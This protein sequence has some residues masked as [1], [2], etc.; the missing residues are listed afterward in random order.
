MSWMQMI[1]MAD[2]RAGN[3]LNV[4]DQ[5][6][7]RV[8]AVRQ[9]N[10]D[11]AEAITLKG[12][13]LQEQQRINNFKMNMQL[14]DH[15]LRSQQMALQERLMPLK[16]QT[17]Q[18]RL[19][20]QQRQL[21]LTERSSQAAMFNAMYGGYDNILAGDLID[22]NNAALADEAIK[23]K[24]EYMERLLRGEQF[25]G[26][27]Y[28]Q[29]W[30]GRSERIKGEAFTPGDGYDASIHQRL[31]VF[32]EAPATAYGIKYNPEVKNN[33][34]GLAMNAIMGGGARSI[35][36]LST[37]AEYAP[38]EMQ[39]ITEMMNIYSTNENII[40]SQMKDALDL[41][42]QIKVVEDEDTKRTLI[43]YHKDVI[44][45]INSARKQNRMIID[46]AA[47]E[48]FTLP[49][50]RDTPVEEEIERLRLPEE[51]PTRDAPKTGVATKFPEAFNQPMATKINTKAADVERTLGLYTDNQIDMNKFEASPLG[52]I[53]FENL[54]TNAR[55]ITEDLEL[56]VVKQV[57]NKSAGLKLED[58][59]INELIR[60]AGNDIDLKASKLISDAAW[61]VSP[62]K[63]NLRV[64]KNAFNFSG[65][66]QDEARKITISPLGDD[67]STSKLQSGFVIRNADDLFNILA[68]VPASKRQAA[69]QE[70]Y[71]LLIA[72]PII[73]S[74]R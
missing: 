21:E 22:N 18:L 8:L 17:E 55:A 44:N 63:S 52:G 15:G 28:L 33:R 41:E 46:S 30:R 58:F 53:D 62:M 10:A 67:D 60:L 37:G 4:M 64:A 65:N 69:Q 24:S 42:K 48:R 26:D 11:K 47:N 43:E 7:S 68:K 36:E 3:S 19:Q 74:A 38:E 13:E 9:N 71:S 12:I 70:L 34:R 2:R 14:A 73:Q 35:Y 20:T 32:G 25:T 66:M 72:A 40:K 56:S 6:M 57:Q 61:S 50:F 31:S 23:H 39:G 54:V 29:A 1:E 5:A 51:D 27:E 45:N 59:Q 16:M 49:D